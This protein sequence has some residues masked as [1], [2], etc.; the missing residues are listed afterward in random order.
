M[1]AIMRLSLA[2]LSRWRLCYNYPC[3]S[4]YEGGGAISGVCP[5]N[6]AR[7][8]TPPRK[9][10][11]CSFHT[12]TTVANSSPR[13]VIVSHRTAAAFKNERGPGLYGTGRRQN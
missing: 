5:G 6:Q 10:V 13:H 4:K 11:S 12:A 8:V 3:T 7:V 9:N 2:R 1:R